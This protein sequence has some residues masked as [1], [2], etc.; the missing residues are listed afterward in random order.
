MKVL[1]FLQN[2]W[3]KDPARAEAIYAS[4]AGDYDRIARLD[5]AYLFMG[6]LT[7][8]RLQG[9]F[10]ETASTDITWT[11]ASPKMGGRSQSSFP[12][13]PTHIRTVIIHH[14]P[15]I[16]LLFGKV[17]QEGVMSELLSMKQSGTISAAGIP[18]I[19]GPHPAARHSTVTQELSKMA[20]RL[21]LMKSEAGG[22]A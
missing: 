15:V 1:A 20:E 3:F 19:S 21:D 13:D 6:C 10:G 2:Q 17:A 5:A 22:G 16:I 7:G 11:N 4:H 9:A 18:T 8:R 14:K 12:A